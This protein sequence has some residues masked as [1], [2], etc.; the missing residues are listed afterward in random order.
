[1]ECLK[2]D[3]RKINFAESMTWNVW[4]QFG[5]TLGEPRCGPKL[6]V[7]K[8]NM[9]SGEQYKL[10]D[11]MILHNRKCTAYPIHIRRN[12][13]LLRKRVSM[14]ILCYFPSSKPPRN[15]QKE[16]SITLL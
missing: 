1:M 15:A 3:L 10:V 7:M 2:I 4:K 12:R 14:E 16:K 9:P 13:K 11:Y 5:V 8:H 6:N